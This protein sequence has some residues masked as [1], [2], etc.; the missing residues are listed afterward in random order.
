VTVIGVRADD[1]VPLIPTML[2]AARYLVR[3]EAEARDLTH[4][5]LEIGLRRLH[6]LR[7][8]EKLRPWLLA[9]LAREA[10]RLRRR[11][12]HLIAL[13]P[14]VHDLHAAITADDR[15]VAVHEALAA[16][17]LRI[18]VAVVLHHLIGLTVAETAGAMRV[19][20][21]TVKSELKVGLRRLREDLDDGTR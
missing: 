11:L 18:R 4:A 12:R 19:S 15:D 7:D 9:I 3:E 10:L 1:L 6:Q 2:A 5:S 13:D 14:A 16:L 21:N 8:P 17:P 20:E